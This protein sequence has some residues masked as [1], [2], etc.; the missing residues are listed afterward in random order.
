MARE[1]TQRAAE[2]KLHLKSRRAPVQEIDAIEENP[3]KL[4]KQDATRVIEGLQRVLGTAYTLYHQYKKHQVVFVGPQFKQIEQ[5]LQMV[6]V[7]TEALASEAAERIHILGAIPAMNQDSLTASSIFAPEP[8]GALNLRTMLENDVKAEAALAR[9]MRETV[10]V[11]IK[12]GDY[13]TEDLLKRTLRVQEKHTYFVGA[14]LERESLNL[15]L[16][17]VMT[18]NPEHGPQEQGRKNGK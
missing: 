3:I 8:E 5:V 9:L 7:E 17:G 6:G 13:G 2:S 14:F 11:A 1:S 4:A 16:A 15:Q 18:E 12:A 10:D